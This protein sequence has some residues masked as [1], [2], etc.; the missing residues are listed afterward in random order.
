MYVWLGG[1][2]AP[3]SNVLSSFH[4]SAHSQRTLATAEFMSP[5]TGERRSWPGLLTACALAYGTLIHQREAYCI[6]THGPGSYWVQSGE[7][8]KVLVSRGGEEQNYDIILAVG[9]RE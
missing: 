6:Q 4:C 3:V 7:S 2:G 1:G 5:E 8:G 9:Q